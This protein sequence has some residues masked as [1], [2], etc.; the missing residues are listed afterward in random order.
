MKPGRGREKAA[1]SELLKRTPS[2]TEP[3]T[4]AAAWRRPETAKY[5]AAATTTMVRTLV[6]PSEVTSRMASFS[7]GGPT[8]REGLARARKNCK[9][10][11]SKALVSPSTTS[12]ASKPKPRM[13]VVTKTTPTSIRLSTSLAARS[14]ERSADMDWRD[15]GTRWITLSARPSPRKFGAMDPR[16]FSPVFHSSIG[17]APHERDL[18]VAAATFAT[19]RRLSLAGEAPLSLA[20]LWLRGAVGVSPLGAAEAD[21]DRSTVSVPG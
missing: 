11:S 21:P 8:G 3:S 7:Q 9:T 20:R 18:D 14:K 10:C 5:P 13:N 17:P 2:A 4:I 1:L 6:L 16:R 19:A 12:L 15:A